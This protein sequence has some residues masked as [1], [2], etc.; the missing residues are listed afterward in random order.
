MAITPRDL[1]AV[2]TEPALQRIHSTL[3][4]P[5]TFAEDAGAAAVTLPV[6]TPVS[7]NTSTDLWVPWLHNGTNGTDAIRGIVWP[8]AITINATGGGE[9]IGSVMIRGEAHYE[10]LDVSV[11]ASTPAQLV[12][13]LQQG[14]TSDNLRQLGIDIKGLD[15]IF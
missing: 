7:F 15:K 5:K 2:N 8:L 11:V 3:N 9:T 12:T 13:A 4:E 14:G 1:R 6:G 10:D